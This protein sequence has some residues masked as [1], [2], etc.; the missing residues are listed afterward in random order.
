MS[1]KRGKDE[2]PELEG[3]MFISAAERA[4]AEQRVRQQR[5]AEAAKKAEQEK[6][7]AVSP[8]CLPQLYYHEC[9]E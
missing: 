6:I 1:G 9:W 7:E 8:A 3:I 4:K 2:Y 5:E